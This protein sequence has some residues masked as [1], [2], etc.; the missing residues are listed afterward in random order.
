MEDF[1]SSAEVEELLDAIASAVEQTG[2]QRVAGEGRRDLV[3]EVN[4]NKVFLQRLNLW[5]INDTVKRYFLDPE[6]G[7]NPLQR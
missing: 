7:R 5:K 3:D 2:K 4:Y 6:L 1:L